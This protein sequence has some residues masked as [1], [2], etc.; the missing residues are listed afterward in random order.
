MGDSEKKFIRSVKIRIDDAVPGMLL[1]EDIKNNAGGVV[2]A[3]D[4]L[5]TKDSIRLLKKLDIFSIYIEKLETPKEA[6]CLRGKTA[7]VF[8]CSLYFR[9]MFSKM[10]YKLGMFVV[11][12]VESAKDF[13]ASAL[14]HKPDFLVVDINPSKDNEGLDVIK[15]LRGKLAGSKF[16]AVSADRNKQIVV[17]SIKAGA[18]DFILK[19]VKWGDFKP[20]LHKLFEDKNQ[21]K[22]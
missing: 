9:H 14:R 17:D 22:S 6:N 1:A 18:D 13:A 20:R 2:V 19:P 15:K 8:D 7:I 11:D 5:L 10:L 4:S 16:L 21:K 12:D 3:A